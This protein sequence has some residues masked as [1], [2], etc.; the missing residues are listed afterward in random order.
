MIHVENLK[1]WVEVLMK[2]RTYGWSH[3]HTALSAALGFRVNGET[4]RWRTNR[5][6]QEEWTFAA[7]RI[8]MIR[9]GTMKAKLIKGRWRAT[10]VDPPEPPNGRT[11]VARV[12]VDASGI[13]LLH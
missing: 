7:T 2:D 9:A 10:A 5:L 4:A 3:A 8:D 6:T 11:V 1:Q 12:R 13:Q